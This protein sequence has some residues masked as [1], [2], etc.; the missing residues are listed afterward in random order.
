MPSNDS[1]KAVEQKKQ[2][3]SDAQKSKDLQLI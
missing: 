3:K 2:D 1:K